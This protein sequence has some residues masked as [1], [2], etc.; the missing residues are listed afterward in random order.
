MVISNGMFGTGL[1]PFLLQEDAS[2]IV[3]ITK[4]STN[5]IL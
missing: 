3:V 1:T 2:S 5:F 4:K